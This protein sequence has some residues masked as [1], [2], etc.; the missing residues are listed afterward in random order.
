MTVP[1]WPSE[2]PRPVRQTYSASWADGRQMRAADYGPPSARL[3]TS[4]APQ[5]ATLSLKLTRAEKA[6]FDD[7]W[8]RELRRGSLPF[9]MPDPVTDGWELLSSDGAPVLDDD[10]E[11]ILLAGTWTCLFA[12]DGLPQ[13]TLQGLTFNIN[14]SVVVMP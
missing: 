3:R 10:G 11:P 8:Q 2:L 12:Q 6:M 7:F 14:F 5:M 9:T 4:S 1:A 13:E